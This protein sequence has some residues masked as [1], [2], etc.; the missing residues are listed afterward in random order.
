VGCKVFFKLAAQEQ[1][2]RNNNQSVDEGAQLDHLPVS[3]GRAI[4]GHFMSDTSI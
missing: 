4:L 2:L 1:I 3:M